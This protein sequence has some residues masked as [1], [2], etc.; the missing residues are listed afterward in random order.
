MQTHTRVCCDATEVELYLL[1]DGDLTLSP[2]DDLLSE[3][4]SSA[5]FETASHLLNKSENGASIQHGQVPYLHQLGRSNLEYT[6][7][8]AGGANVNMSA[9]V[10]IGGSSFTAFLGPLHQSF[11]P[12][13]SGTLSID[14]PI[15][16]V[17]VSGTSEISVSVNARAIVFTVPASGAKV[18]FFWGS[19]EHAFEAN[20]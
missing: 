11:I 14:I 5:S 16:Q 7:S 6:V 19:E 4:S 10:T 8:D 9:T 2:F 13:G 20:S 18:E 1:G 17:P 15:E 3:T 12:Q